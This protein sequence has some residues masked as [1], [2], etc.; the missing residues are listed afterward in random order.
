MKSLEEI[1]LAHSECADKC[2]GFNTMYKDLLLYSQEKNAWKIPE[3]FPNC[4]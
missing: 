4:W 3:R 2:T 1:F